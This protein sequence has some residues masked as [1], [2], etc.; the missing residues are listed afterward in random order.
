[1]AGQAAK[2]QHQRPAGTALRQEWFRR[3]FNA[4]DLSGR[5]AFKD[6]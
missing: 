5:D 3:G 4:G 1:M 2:Q 6:F